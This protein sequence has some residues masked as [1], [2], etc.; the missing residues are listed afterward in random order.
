MR[1]NVYGLFFDAAEEM[2]M[3]LLICGDTVPTAGSAPLFETGDT[4]ALFGRVKDEFAAHD[5]VIVNLECALTD[6]EHKIRKFGP[7]LKGPV[8]TAATLRAAGVTDCVL[9]NNHILDFGVGGLHDTERLLD[10]AGLRWFGCGE[11]AEEAKK[12]YYI[13]RNG[14]KVAFL[15]FNEHEYT[16]ALG[17]QAGAAPF[18]P[19]DA[20][21]RIASVKKTADRLVVLYHGGKEYCEYPSPRLRELCHAMTELGADVVLCQHSHIIGCM[22]RHAGGTIVY[23]QGNF[24]FVDFSEQPFWSRGLMISLDI[25][26]DVKVRCIPIVAGEKGVDLAGA[27]EA[28]AIL[29]GFEARSEELKDG[30]WLEGW[31]RFVRENGAGYID[32]VRQALDG[33]ET[34]RERMAHYL[35]CEA[36]LDMLRE[37]FRTWHNTQT[38]GAQEA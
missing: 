17:N 33:D 7:N 19:F 22:E 34:H 35:D 12:P 28:R 11:N 37:L 4:N 25:G 8:Q 23:G 9:A 14:K 24:H 30:R 6:S 16:Y 3:R 5:R 13:E 36:H 26:A 20:M 18:D 27:A 1:S 38:D 15:A 29:D 32:C 10:A 21:A 2:D 31:R